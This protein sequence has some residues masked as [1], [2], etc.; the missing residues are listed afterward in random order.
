MSFHFPPAIVA[1]REA[2]VPDAA[3]ADGGGDGE[4][5]SDRADSAAIGAAAMPSHAEALEHLS[6]ELLEAVDH[7]LSDQDAHL[8][9]MRLSRL[10]TLLRLQLARAER[11]TGAAIMERGDAALARLARAR[12]AECD[13]ISEQLERF[14]GRYGDAGSAL[15]NLP[16]FRHD[17][18]ALI[19]HLAE[20]IEQE[21]VM[22]PRLAACLAQLP[23]A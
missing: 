5:G 13:A 12:A 21:R 16:G 14:A 20:R 4:P 8:L 15:E 6:G 19:G 23:S 9:G 10:L 18:R 22:M 3:S 17:M 1:P 11:M 7:F 2:V